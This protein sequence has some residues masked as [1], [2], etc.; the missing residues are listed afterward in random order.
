M[1]LALRATD[2]NE[3]VRT[4]GVTPRGLLSLGPLIKGAVGRP[5]Y[6]VVVYRAGKK[7]EHEF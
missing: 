4:Q 7:S 2:D 3:V 5:A 6:R 1:F